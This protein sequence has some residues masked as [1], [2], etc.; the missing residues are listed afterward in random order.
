MHKLLRSEVVLHMPM[1][2]ISCSMCR[3]RVRQVL[4]EAALIAP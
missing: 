1:H 4:S 3:A 2:G